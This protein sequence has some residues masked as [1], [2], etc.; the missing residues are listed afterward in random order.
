[1][2]GEYNIAL[3]STFGASGEQWDGGREGQKAGWGRWGGVVDVR[4]DMLFSFRFCALALVSPS[5]V[6]AV[7][8]ESDAMLWLFA[9]SWRAFSGGAGTRPGFCLVFLVTHLLL[10]LFFVDQSAVRSF[11]SIGPF[12]HSIRSGHSSNRFD[13]AIRSID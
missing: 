8:G 11:D 5:C 4:H 9:C 2:G 13:R 3:L 1:M 7:R 10:G 6:T 12:V